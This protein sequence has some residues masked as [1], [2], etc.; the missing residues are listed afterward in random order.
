[1]RQFDLNLVRH[2]LQ[3]LPQA[4]DLGL[5]EALF[6]ALLNHAKQFRPNFAC[7]EPLGSEAY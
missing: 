3:C 5:A 6:P 1:M 4:A 2:V 7:S